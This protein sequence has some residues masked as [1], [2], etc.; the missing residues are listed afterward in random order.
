MG[1]LRL[2]LEAVHRVSLARDRDIAV[3]RGLY[4]SV[5][6]VARRLN[7]TL[8]LF[9]TVLTHVCDYF[10]RKRDLRV[11]YSSGP[12]WFDYSAEVFAT[13]GVISC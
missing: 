10:A 13:H 8:R 2:W 9:T 1:R 5:R 12:A 7:K 3:A 11:A 4:R 6:I